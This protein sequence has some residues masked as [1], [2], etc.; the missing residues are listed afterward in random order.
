MVPPLTPELALN[1]RSGAAPRSAGAAPRP[2]I[3]VRGAGKV[4]GSGRDGVVALK[5]ADFAVN[6][7]EFVSIVG[8]SGCGKTTVLRL[9][10]GITSPSSGVVR[11]DGL[12]PSRA[13]LPIGM[14]FQTPVLL[15]WR[16]ILA[17]VLL[18]IELDGKNVRSH[19]PRARELLSLVGLAGFEHMRP[20][21]LSGGMEQRAALCRALINDPVLLL[22][23]EPFGALDSLTRERLNLELQ[24]VWMKTRKTVILVTHSIA[25]AVF[26][27]D[28]VLVMSGRP[29]RIEKDVAIRL[30]RP[31]E[32]AIQDTAEFGRCTREVR[33]ALEAVMVG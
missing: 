15:P 31:R 10:A 7:E 9:L 20:Y 18:P 13:R 5:E 32:L 21:Q 23:D 3:E 1:D 25:E 30:P 28:R 22:A 8:P 26:L 11:V 27:G 33:Q 12:D 19:L 24:S 14:V 2:L 4:F 16:T 6:G 29:G 17:N